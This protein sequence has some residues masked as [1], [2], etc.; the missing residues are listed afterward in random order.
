M[1]T[2]TAG[3]WLRSATAANVKK[4]RLILDDYA[5]GDVASGTDGSIWARD[6]TVIKPITAATGFSAF[7]LRIDAQDTATG[8]L[9]IGSLLIGPV[10][11]FGG[12]YSWGRGLS[13]EMSIDRTEGRGG[14]RTARQLA[15]MRRSVEV[16]WPDGLDTSPVGQTVPAGDYYRSSTGGSIIAGEGDAL[17]S[18]RG[19]LGLLS[20]SSGLVAYLG[21]IPIESSPT[22]ITINHREQH[23][24]GRIMSDTHRVD[25]VQ[26][27]EW[28]S[29][30]L[31][32]GRFR[33]DEE[34]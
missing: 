19:M 23:L 27:E 7:K 17:W 11:V 25:N 13:V 3:V 21:R 31:R 6:V 14:T 22:T 26:G 33:I 4:L 29:E 16:G 8:D 1:S 34:I 20:R 9:R 32:G 12:E 2:N 30:V 28:R 15:P 5:T 10:V 24:Y 18:L